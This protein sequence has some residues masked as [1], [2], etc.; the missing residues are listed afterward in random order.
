MKKELSAFFA[1]IGADKK[2]A[3]FDESLSFLANEDRK[4]LYREGELFLLDNNQIKSSHALEGKSNSVVEFDGKSLHTIDPSYFIGRT[5]N[6]SKVKSG[7]Y[8]ASGSFHSNNNNNNNNNN[9]NN[10]NG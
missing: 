4:V 6:K 3:Y 8:D 9:G 10:N 2:S 7:Y 5:R 1:Q